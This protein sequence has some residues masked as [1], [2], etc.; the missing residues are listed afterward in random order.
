MDV[1]S[2]V[3][4]YS[5]LVWWGDSSLATWLVGLVKFSAKAMN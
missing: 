3:L 5:K 4:V 2:V 1:V